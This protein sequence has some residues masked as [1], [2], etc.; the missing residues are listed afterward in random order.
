MNSDSIKE[1]YVFL[2]L[3]HGVFLKLLNKF[4]DDMLDFRP[5]EKSR[6]VREIVVHV[7][8]SMKASNFAIK[9]GR[10]SKEEN[11]QFET[12]D[13]KTVEELVEFCKNS[14]QEIYETAIT[15]NDFDLTKKIPIFYGEFSISQIL[16]FVWPEHAHHYGQLT[17]Y[18]RLLGIEPPFA[19]EFDE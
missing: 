11:E 13:A 5:T 6:S 14:F 9:N 17:V 4:S 10:L 18:A 1:I 15:I 12:T 8:G 7:Y 2:K 3:S 16:Q 19:Y